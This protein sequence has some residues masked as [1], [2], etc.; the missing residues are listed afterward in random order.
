MRTGSQRFLSQFYTHGKFAC[1]DGL[2]L[3]VV[4]IPSGNLSVLLLYRLLLS[5]SPSLSLSLC[6]S[7]SLSSRRRSIMK[8]SLIVSLRMP[9]ICMHTTTGYGRPL[10]VTA[11]HDR[12][13]NIKNAQ[14]LNANSR[15]MNACEEKKT[16]VDKS[17]TDWLSLHIPSSLPPQYLSGTMRTERR[18]VVCC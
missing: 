14:G 18:D 7:L 1:A 2:P 10:A 3:I 12:P 17:L 8:I 4:P 5:L 6:L 16:N 13:K 9:G 15:R 11:C